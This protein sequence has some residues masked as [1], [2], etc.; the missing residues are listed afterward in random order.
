LNPTGP[1][2]IYALGTTDNPP[3]GFILP[4]VQ[5]GLNPAGGPIC[6][7]STVGGADRSLKYAY[8]MNMFFGIQYSPAETWVIEADYLGSEGRDLYNVIDRN[9][10]DGDLIVHNNTLLRLNP[11]FASMNYGDNSGASTYNGLAVSARK[12]FTRGITVQASYTFGRAI[13]YI[14]A[15]G[16]GSGSAYAPVVDA[17]NVRIQRGLSDNDVRNK[18][19]FNFVVPLPALRNTF[20]P[21]RA[22]IGG[23]ELSSLAT[24]QSGLPAWVHTTASFSPVWNNAACNDVVTAGC[25]VI[26]NTGGDYNADGYN[27][28]VPN[29]P[30]FSASNTYSRSQFINGVFAATDFPAPPLGRE[31]NL[32]RNTFRG[33]GLAQIDLSILKNFPL[34]FLHEGAKLQF[35][36][37]SYNLLNRVNLTGFDTDLTSGTFGRATSTFTPRTFQFAARIEF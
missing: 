18:L 26:G 24:L 36:A 31:G 1:Q 29:A 4:G 23:W 34:A 12:M 7:L 19:S 9:R 3:Y 11:Y 21:V 25:Q 30:P 32:G 5:A 13:D 14:N 35:R 27:F 10:V 16:A 37:E 6:C 22:V 20:A 28:D 2:P 33:P 17:Y 15:P 8:A